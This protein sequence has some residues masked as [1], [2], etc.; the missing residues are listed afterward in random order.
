V[1]LFVSIKEIPFTSYPFPSNTFLKNES[2]VRSRVI[3]TDVPLIPFSA[4]TILAA[5][6]SSVKDSRYTRLGDLS[7][8]SALDAHT[9]NLLCSLMQYT[10]RGN[11]QPPSNMFSTLR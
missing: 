6:P 5:S 11:W 9:L 8:A 3:N 4:S 2:S 1:N 7:Q 10:P